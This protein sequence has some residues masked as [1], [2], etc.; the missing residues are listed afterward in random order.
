MLG[1][2]G[3]K[4]G[5]GVYSPGWARVSAAIAVLAVVLIGAR[6]ADTAEL[7]VQRPIDL[8]NLPLLIVEH[9]HLIE[10]HSDMRGLGDIAV[11]WLMPSKGTAIDAVAAGTVDFATVDLA[12]F[13]AAWDERLGS[14]QDVR[15]L[16]AL[17]RMP[18]VLVTRN[19]AVQTIRDFT[20]KDRIAVAN[21]KIGGAVLMLEM[22]AAQEWGG[23]RFNKLDPLTVARSDDDAMAALVSGKSEID[24][25]FSHTPFADSELGN[26]AVHR[27][28]DSF[29][30]V[31]P[32]SEA[33]LVT[34]TRFHDDNSMLCSAV[35]AAL[36][37]AMAL[38]K[39]EP[40][41]AAEIYASM[42]KEGDVSVE[43]LADMIGD[44][45]LSFTTVPAGVMRVADF[46]SRT[47]RTKHRPERWQDLFFAEAHNLPG[48]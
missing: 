5:A 29:D 27:V 35:L 10:K 28:M 42:V 11:R 23:D 46:M 7:R 22:A 20:D 47:G 1:S 44:P 19:P 31:G 41:A 34:T 48:N 8:A 30:I 38:I 24:A 4:S 39:S 14:A 3:A 40:G 37:E 12:A 15:A 45:D 18:Y 25:H 43:D 13:V 21:G 26:P 33:T 17:E 2:F 9:E 32:H 36:E 6:V 16:A